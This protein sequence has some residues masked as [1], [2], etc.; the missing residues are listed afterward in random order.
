MVHT[1]V[2]ENNFEMRLFAW[3]NL[4]PYYFVF[5]KQNYARYGSYYVET[6]KQLDKRYPGLRPFFDTVGLS[7]QAQTKFPLRTSIDQRGEQSINRDAKTSGGIK[8]FASDANSVLKW[9]L[10]RPDQARNTNALRQLAGLSSNCGSYKP[11]RPS[12]ILKSEKAVSEAV[13][14][15]EEEFINPFVGFD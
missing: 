9:C 1:S 11:L 2:Q 3:E 13:R 10:N 6:L 4:L 12:Q 7:V 15:I 5:N 14:V 8:S